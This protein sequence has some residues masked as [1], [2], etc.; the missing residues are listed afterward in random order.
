MNFFNKFSLRKENTVPGP[1]LKY[2]ALTFTQKFQTSCHHQD[3]Q[4][5]LSLPNCTLFYLNLLLSSGCHE[6][7][8]EPVR[9]LY[10]EGMG[11]FHGY[12]N[13]VKR[14]SSK[15]QNSPIMLTS[16]LNQILMCF[17]PLGH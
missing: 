17:K 12:V 7:I 4:N 16:V 15:T 2:N 6:P 5:P 11:P 9:L 13:E 1:D 3:S 10:S 8:Y 14:D